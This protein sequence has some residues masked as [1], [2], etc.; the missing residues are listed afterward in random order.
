MQTLGHCNS[1]CALDHEKIEQGS[2]TCNGYDKAVKGYRE[3]IFG[4]QSSRLILFTGLC[5]DPSKK[6]RR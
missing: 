2:K 4:G 5:D 6:A 3:G 1:T